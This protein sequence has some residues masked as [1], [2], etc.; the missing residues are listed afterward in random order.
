LTRDLR[1]YIRQ[2]NLRLIVG[3]LILLFIVGDGLIYLF[4]GSSAAAMGFLCLLAGLAPVAL[5]TLIIFLLD[6]VTKRANRD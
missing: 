6:W 4:Y 2:T 5:V 1:K 3:A